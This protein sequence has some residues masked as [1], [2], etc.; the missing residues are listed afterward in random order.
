MNLLVRQRLQ[1]S[2]DVHG[3]LDPLCPDRLVAHLC[4]DEIA[5]ERVCVPVE[6]DVEGCEEVTE[7]LMRLVLLDLVR[8]GDQ[9]F[10]LHSGLEQRPHPRRS[11]AEPASHPPGGGELGRICR[12][13]P[14]EEGVPHVERDQ[15]MWRVGQHRDRHA[16]ARTVGLEDLDERLAMGRGSHP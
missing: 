6:A 10:P 13:I 1:C 16:L 4:R 3:R 7:H 9:G 14:P 2:H 8:L 5:H 15:A 12:P 11:P